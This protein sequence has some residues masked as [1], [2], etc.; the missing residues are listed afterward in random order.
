[1][2]FHFRRTFFIGYCY[3][4]IKYI[5]DCAENC[6]DGNTN[7][8]YRQHTFKASIYMTFDNIVQYIVLK[9]KKNKHKI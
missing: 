1:M 6:V 4:R 9:N 8:M 5:K 3:D 7:V 2:N